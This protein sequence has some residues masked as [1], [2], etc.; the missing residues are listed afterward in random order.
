MTISN[1]ISRPIKPR[2]DVHDMLCSRPTSSTM[3]HL[4]IMCLSSQMTDSLSS[5]SLGK[6]YS[7]S[8]SPVD[9]SR[10]ARSRVQRVWNTLTQYAIFDNFMYSGNVTL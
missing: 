4:K 8:L 3:P 7:T 1:L 9:R 6:K 2:L 10:M 5:S